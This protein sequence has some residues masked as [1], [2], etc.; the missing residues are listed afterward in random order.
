MRHPSSAQAVHILL[1]VAFLV[2][3]CGALKRPDVVVTFTDGGCT[4]RGPSD[5]VPN[6]IVVRVENPTENDYA[7]VIAVLKE[8]STQ[9][10]LEAWREEGTP[11]FLER[12]LAHL[13]PGP[14]K[15]AEWTV[16]LMEDREN[17]F[18][19]AEP[20]GVLSVPGVF[21]PGE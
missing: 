14:G 11:P 8:S 15:E 20:A 4:F 16:D 21:V 18:V 2:S 19:C 9:A 1:W 7:L 5:D 12:M 10:D 13:D 6:P 17:H 3:A